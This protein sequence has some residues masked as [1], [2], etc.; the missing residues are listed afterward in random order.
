MLKRIAIGTLLLAGWSFGTAWAEDPLCHDIL[1]GASKAS[2]ETRIA[3][4]G[5][6]VNGRCGEDRTPLVFAALYGRKEIAAVLIAHGANVN[7][8]AKDNETPLHFAAEAN[9]KDVAELLIAHGADVN[10]KRTSGWTPL[11]EAAMTGK[12]DVAEVLIAHGANVNDAGNP[13][14]KASYSSRG[15]STDLVELLLAK[16]ADVNTRAPHGETALHGPCYMG[17]KEVAEL[18][19]AKG[20]DV[21]AKDERGWTP[22]HKASYYLRKDVAEV[23]LAHGADV[24]A[25]NEKGET[26]LTVARQTEAADGK[27]AEKK[28]AMIGLLAGGTQKPANNPRDLFKQQLSQFSAE[29]ETLRKSIIGLALTLQPP[30][31]I[32]QEAEDAAGRAEYIF[33]H[34][35]SGDAMLDTAR[36]YLKAI[37]AA[38]W[39]ANYYFNLCTVLE[40]TPYTQQ[41]LHACR[42]YLEASPN[43]PDAAEM[44]R[45]IAGLRYSVEK[46]KEQMKRRTTDIFVGT[47]AMYGSGGVAGKVAGKDV[48]LKLAVNWQASPPRHQVFAACIEGDRAQYGDYDLVPTDTWTTLCNTGFHVVIKPE[49]AGFVGLSSSGEGNLR[50]TL[51]E[52]FALK[53]EAMKRSPIVYGNKSLIYLAYLHGGRDRKRAGFDLYQSD[54]NGNLLR[55]DPRSLPDEFYS[56]EEHKKDKSRLLDI[57]FAF[58]T[59]ED[60]NP[61][62]VCGDE[63]ARKAGYHFGEKE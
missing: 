32:P 43:A 27:T 41:A 10:A 36:E 4:E 15:T 51:D 58:V 63:F 12:K 8:R 7:Y 52:L 56:L 62:R 13:L 17:R 16:G 19:L 21:N 38:P 60:A 53:Q 29:N 48:A 30:P 34:A 46:N 2:V 45:H 25:K 42:L 49:G 22:L 61:L 18:L 55:Q 54:C 28:Q 11:D 59:M 47:N 23:L 33:R 5:A 24:N 37:E 1:I 35:K 14:I 50:V 3:V 20:A 31:A 26:P 9:S 40:K 6:N 44:R 39:V 57:K